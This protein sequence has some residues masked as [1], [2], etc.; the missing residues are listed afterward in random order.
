[1]RYFTA[2][3]LER[4][5]ST[6]PAIA[7]AAEAEWEAANARY[8]QYA[9]GLEASLPAPLREFAGL[10]LHDALVQSMARD[11]GRLIMVLKKDIPPQD[12]VILCYEL[13]DEPVLGPFVRQPR[14]WRLPARFDFDE[15]ERVEDGQKTLYSQAIVFDNGWELRLRFHNVGVTQAAAWVPTNGVASHVSAAV[16]PL[17]A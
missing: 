10:L 2:D 16:S 6:D 12:L 3:L 11:G 17:P 5:R 9:Q 4:F 1:M 14:E 7:R 8:D 13:E 15:L